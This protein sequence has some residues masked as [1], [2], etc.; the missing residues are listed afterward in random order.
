MS[1]LGRRGALAA[2]TALLSLAAVAPEPVPWPGGAAPDARAVA[3]ARDLAI[4]KWRHDRY[5]EFNSAVENETET[6]VATI[7][8]A[9]IDRGEFDIETIQF[10]GRRLFQLP[11]RADLGL[12]GARSDGRFEVVHTG[13]QPGLDSHACEGCHSVGGFDG[14]GTFTQS[15]LLYGDG[16]RESS[17]TRRNPPALLG[18]GLVQA[19]GV[20]MSAE[21]AQI[22]EEARARSAA[23]GAPVRLPLS[24]RGVSFGAVTAR[25]DGSLDTSEVLGVSA[26][27]IVRPFGWKGERRLIRDFITDAARTHFGVIS[28]SDALAARGAP[29]ARLGGGPDWEDPDGDGVRRE[30][31]EG[32]ITTGALYLELVETPTQIPPSDPALVARWASGERLFEQIGCAGCHVPSLQWSGRVLEEAPPGSPPYP[33]KLLTQGDPPRSGDQIALYSDLRRHDMGEGLADRADSPLGVGRSV[34]LTRPLW[35][36]AETAP[37]LHDGAAA[38]IPDAILAHG[39]E[40][41]AAREAFAALPPESAS[42]LHVFLLSLTRAPNLAMAR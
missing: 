8:Q 42:D 4:F 23:S 28:H 2:A 17:A 32:I 25:P 30:L 39:G 3:A 18:L 7:L 14:A 22:A 15:P 34:F 6:A 20:E 9:Q 16:L 27:L 41:A 19:L 21:L 29:S 37:Y 1:R 33:V 10:Y 11:W 31:E 35:G 5:L 40:A 13:D 12:G 26:D 24:A 38:T 36:L